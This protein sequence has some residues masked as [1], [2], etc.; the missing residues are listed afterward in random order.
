MTRD[1]KRWW[2]FFGELFALTSR[3][4]D[5]DSDSEQVMTTNKWYRWAFLKMITPSEFSETYVLFNKP[6]ND[7]L[8]L[9]SFP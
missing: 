2:L 8:P 1:G 6:A 7:N 4:I 9:S 3:R 5:F